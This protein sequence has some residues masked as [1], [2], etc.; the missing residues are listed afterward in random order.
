MAFGGMGV[1]TPDGKELAL[2]KS[3]D[4]D[5]RVILN[6]NFTIMKF[7]QVDFEKTIKASK[8]DIWHVLAERFGDIGNISRN[9]LRSE[10]ISEK[11]SGVG[12]T[13]Y[14]ELPKNGFLK[15]SVT[16]WDALDEF[17][18]EIQESSMPMEKGGKLN[19]K[20]TEK[21]PDQTKIRVAATFR[22][23][24]LP[25]LSPL[26]KPMMLKIIS[27]MLKDFEKELEASPILD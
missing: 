23:K 11:H 12:T 14:C 21:A 15:E 7:Y 4:A 18:F 2:K 27:G 19:F 25:F 5:Q 24:Y 20:L 26:L 9:V 16:K 22:L 17:E 3:G 8:A 6:L 10:Y 1:V 13:R